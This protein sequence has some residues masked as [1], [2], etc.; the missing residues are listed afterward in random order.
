MKKVFQHSYSTFF[1]F[2]IESFISFDLEDASF[3]VEGKAVKASLS[4]R[5]EPTSKLAIVTV[6]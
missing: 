6:K 5:V 3:T 2:V 1:F 4:M